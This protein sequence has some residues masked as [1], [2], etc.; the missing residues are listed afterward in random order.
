LSQL[1]TVGAH[2]ALLGTAAFEGS[3]RQVIYSTNYLTSSLVRAAS[4]QSRSGQAAATAAQRNAALQA[5][6][7][8]TAAAAVTA[9]ANA[10]AAGVKAAADRQLADQARLV[11]GMQQLHL[12][13]AEAALGQATTASQG[14]RG[15]A[16]VGVAAA[17]A[18]GASAAAAAFEKQAAASEKAAASAE[19]MAARTAK[20]AQ[21][22]GAEL[23]AFGN[24]AAAGANAA[25]TGFSAASGIIIGAILAVVAAVALI[26]AAVVGAGINAVKLGADYSQ[27]MNTVQTLTQETNSKMSELN[28]VILGIGTTTTKSMG[29]AAAAAGEL[30]KGGVSVNDAMSGALKSVVNLSTASAGELELAAAAKAV[31]NGMAAFNLEG[32]QSVRVA[33]AI[34][35]VA[36]STTA[37]YSDLAHSLQQVGTVAHSL[38]YSIEDTYT[39]IGLLSLNA[40]KGSDAGTAL[41]TMFQH[42]EHPSQAAAKELNKYGVSL[43]DA[44]GAARPLR[45][46]VINLEKAFG[47]QAIAAGKLTQQTR[48]AAL[49]TIFGTDGQRAALSLISQGVEGYDRLAAAQAKSYCRRRRR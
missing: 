23:E 28:D 19:A 2:V 24:S 21:T 9:A 29:D 7:A 48:D 42:L 18:A 1:P 36:Q 31:A 34:T 13:A 15:K 27:A 6:A 38:N 12:Q 40:I 32:T 46:V 37:T 49:A 47:T 4:D 10:Q 11:A 44:T 17:D 35:G 39:A 20:A 8:E 25:A 3:I 16:A 45:D 43:Y 33:D 5:K 41:R 14:V 22:A 30:A 26:A